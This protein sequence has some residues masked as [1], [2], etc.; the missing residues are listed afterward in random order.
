MNR[1]AA[2]VRTLVLAGALCTA[3]TSI[4]CFGISTTDFE[5][6]V[7]TERAAAAARAEQVAANHA[8]ALASKDADLGS[9]VAKSMDLEIDLAELEIAN[10][11]LESSLASVKEINATLTEST[12]AAEA[13]QKVLEMNLR[14]AEDAAIAARRETRWLWY[15]SESD[16]SLAFEVAGWASTG[17]NGSLLGLNGYCDDEGSTLYLMS[18]V[19]TYEDGIEYETKV[20]LDGGRLRNETLW[21][22]GGSFAMFA[23][24]TLDD[25][26][27]SKTVLL[28]WDY[29][30]I[31]EITF[32]TNQLLR[33]FPM[34][35]E[36]CAGNRPQEYS[37]IPPNTVIVSDGRSIQQWSSPPA[38]TI[39]PSASYTAVMETTAGTI[40]VELLS[41]EAPNTVNNFVFLLF[42][43]S[44]SVRI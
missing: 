34:P 29:K 31:K 3:L 32:D 33:M 2:R 38:M 11:S 30:G 42:S 22:H 9:A 37:Q 35:E 19:A 43:Q 14:K 8:A 41:S 25:L 40:T 4:G 6:A 16:N 21:G 24:L 26:W 27:K 12:K 10:R 28:Q 44:S 15:Q 23:D 7:A 39:N 13:K 36:L 5:A 17:E 20:A 1:S 18:N